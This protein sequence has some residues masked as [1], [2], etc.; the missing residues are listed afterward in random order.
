MAVF[1]VFFDGDVF[2]TLAAVDF[3]KLFNCFTVIAYRVH[4]AVNHIDWKFFWDIVNVASIVDCT[5]SSHHIGIK[6]GCK[7]DIAP[8]VGEEH[9]NVQ[10]ISGKPVVICFLFCFFVIV[11]KSKCI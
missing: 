3:V 1:G 7:R 2:D 9:L 5:K 11:T 6:G 10:L 8:L 4:T